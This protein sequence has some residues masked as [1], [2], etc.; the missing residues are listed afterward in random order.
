M[1]LLSLSVRFLI[2]TFDLLGLDVEIP[3][4]K[5]S[6]AYFKYFLI[7]SMIEAGKSLPC[8]LDPVTFVN[9]CY[10]QYFNLSTSLGSNPSWAKR[11][12]LPPCQKY[13]IVLI[14]FC[15]CSPVKSGNMRAF[16]NFDTQTPTPI[17]IICLTISDA[18]IALHNGG[19]V[20]LE[21]T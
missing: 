16:I 4:G 1:V 17:V 12:V 10:F 5:H 14:Y 9:D 2:C 3:D 21:T 11:W 20:V 7:N 15:F 8:A 13:D 18:A 6:M 19:K